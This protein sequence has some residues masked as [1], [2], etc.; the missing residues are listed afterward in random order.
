MQHH[1]NKPAKDVAAHIRLKAEERR[2]QDEI[3]NDLIEHSYQEAG[4]RYV[5]ERQFE[6]IFSGMRIQPGCRLLEVG[7]G[8]GQFLN[9]LAEK[10]DSAG[11]KLVGLDLSSGLADVRKRSPKNIQ[12]IIADGEQLPLKANAFDIVVFNGSLHHMPDFEKALHEAFR[13]VRLDGH[14]LLFEPVSTFFSRMLHHLLDPFVFKKTKYESPVDEYCKDDFKVS[15]LA[16]IIAASGYDYT[17]SWH[18]FLAYPLTGCYA[19]SRFSR[20]P[21]L[22]KFL[23]RVEDVLQSIP[24]MGRF[25]NFFCWRLS[26]D[27]FRNRVQPCE[28]D[29]A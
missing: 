11:P 5:Y 1:L 3:G 29:R 22:M 4:S 14:I 7:C 18:D 13:V 27:I 23:G 21:G 8:R 26:V 25:F 24:L 6:K 2:W 12:W 15:R 17:T 9:R 28:D 16:D 10:F 20:N 19:G